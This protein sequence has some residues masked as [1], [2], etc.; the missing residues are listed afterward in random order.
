MTSHKLYIQ[1]QTEACLGMG[2]GEE[3]HGAKLMQNSFFHF[4]CVADL[5]VFKDVLFSLRFWKLM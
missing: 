3:G 1:W 2:T 4:L 5:Y